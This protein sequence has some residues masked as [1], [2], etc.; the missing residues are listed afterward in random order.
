MSGRVIEVYSEIPGHMSVNEWREYEITSEPSGE[1]CQVRAAH[2]G[3]IAYLAEVYINTEEVKRGLVRWKEEENESGITRMEDSGG[4]SGQEMQSSEES[5][6]GYEEYSEMKCRCAVACPGEWSDTV[7]GSHGYKC[8]KIY[9]LAVFAE[10]AGL[11]FNEH[12]ARVEDSEVDR[13]LS[14][15]WVELLELPLQYT[16]KMVKGMLA[17]VAK[18]KQVKVA[19]GVALVELRSAEAAQEIVSRFDGLKIEGGRVW[20]RQVPGCG[21]QQ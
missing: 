6:G 2:L 12:N 18:V 21:L 7:H 11:D 19:P 17:Q 10:A 16:V 3:H 1:A 15:R 9:E 4:D 8:R 13:E 14:S 5:A 20:I